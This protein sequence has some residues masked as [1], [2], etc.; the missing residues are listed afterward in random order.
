M[1]VSYSFVSTV[2]LLAGRSQSAPILGLDGGLLNTNDPLIGGLTH[3]LNALPATG[4]LTNGL[5]AV[6]KEGSTEV[7]STN[8]LLGQPEVT[9]VLA[10]SKSNSLLGGSKSGGLLNLSG[11]NGGDSILKTHGLLGNS[12]LKKRLSLPL[13]GELGSLDGFE[14]KAKSMASAVGSKLGGLFRRNSNIQS[15]LPA[16]TPAVSSA[17]SKVPLVGYMPGI[18]KL[19]AA[20]TLPGINV[21]PGLNLIPGLGSTTAAS[22]LG[23]TV[24]QI[25]GTHE[26]ATI[27]TLT[28]GPA[29]GLNT[30]F[31]GFF[32]GMSQ[33]PVVFDHIF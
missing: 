16:V 19:P 22:G 10:V 5:L 4:E 25:A 15:T 27:A 9:D 18:P 3:T 28:D 32:G 24:N 26:R 1:R 8:G 14:A 13:I 30:A 29:E 33:A 7:L 23:A 31:T 11:Y 12:S 21:I 20:S 17:L 6:S 2:I